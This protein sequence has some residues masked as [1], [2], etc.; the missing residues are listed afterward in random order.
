[1]II[2]DVRKEFERDS[3]RSLSMP[4]AGAIVWAIIGLVSTQFEFAVA[5]Y[6]L[7]FSTG[8][9]FPIALAVAKLRGELLASSNNPFAKLM[10]MCVLM[11]NLLWGINIPLAMHAPEFIPLSLGV[12][13]GLHWV[14]Y[15]WIIQHPLGVIHGVLRTLLVVGAW[16]AFPESRIP[17]I[18]LV[19]VLVYGVSIFQMSARPVVTS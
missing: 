19:I 14:V 5:V 15:S 10:G 3:N 16:Y 2:E 7:L 11:V 18:S 9:I 6:I 12:G 8:L 1:M 4:I 17:A 13:M